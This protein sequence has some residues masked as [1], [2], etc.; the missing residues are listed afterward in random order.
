MY[1]PKITGKKVYLSP[2]NPE[3]LETYTRWMN[4]PEVTV[5]LGNH[6][7][8]YSLLKEKESLEHM[9]TSKDSVNLAII[10]KASNQLIGN[11]GLMD[12][13][14]LYRRGDLGIFIGEA[15]FRNRGYGTEAMALL[16]D[17]GFRVL[18]LHNINLKY[19]SF[20]KRGEKAYLKLGFK[21][22][23]RR[24]ESV[25]YNGQFY[26]DVEMDLLE[27]EFRQGPYHNIAQLDLKGYEF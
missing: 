10:D 25:I 4:D 23:G 21:E 3:D 19:F 26:D 7:G 11:C 13:N 16:L 15:D 2:M 17:F 20:N 14:H 5:G 6:S 8:I 9:A 12:I 1:F 18:N 22:V 27:Q 24:R